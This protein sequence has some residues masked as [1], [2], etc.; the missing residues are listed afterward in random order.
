MK[1]NTRW[2][3]LSLIATTSVLAVASTAAAQELGSPITF[4]VVAGVSVPLGDFSD[5]A[6]TG[7]HAG[8]LVQWDTPTYP[9][10]IRLEGVYHAFGDKGAVQTLNQGQQTS[11]ADPNI[12]VGTLNG[13]W[14]FPM[15]QPYAVRP[16]LIGGGG[17]Y[18]KR[19]NG[20]D[21]QTK[22][23]LN[24]GAGITVPLSGFSTIIEARFHIIFDSE[25]GSSNSTFIPI[26]V[27]LLFR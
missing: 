23:G 24:G 20:C 12:I 15:T 14:M 22:F 8:A 4:G 17:I 1:G 2:T 21:S 5:F 10:G 7:W 3:R 11:G 18:N 26:S 13:V 25:A 19:C 9:L 6:E 27:G 16:Y